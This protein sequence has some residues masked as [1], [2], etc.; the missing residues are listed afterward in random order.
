MHGSLILEK[1]NMCC[2]HCS[3]VSGSLGRVKKQWIG[4]TMGRLDLSTRALVYFRSSTRS[5]A[6]S[7][8]API[9]MSPEPTTPTPSARKRHH[10]SPSVSSTAAKKPKKSGSKAAAALVTWKQEISSRFAPLATEVGNRLPLLRVSG[11]A[12]RFEDGDD[13]LVLA[14]FCALTAGAGSFN[15]GV[16][17]FASS[18]GVVKFLEREFEVVPRGIIELWAPGSSRVYALAF[19]EIAASVSRLPT[20]FLKLGK[21]AGLQFFSPPSLSGP[22]VSVS[23]NSFP[24]DYDATTAEEALQKLAFVQSA[25]LSRIA[26]GR[27]GNV[28]TDRLQGTLRLNPISGLRSE[29][30]GMADKSGSGSFRLMRAWAG[31]QE[32]VEKGAEGRS[33]VPAVGWFPLNQDTFNVEVKPFCPV[34]SFDH[35]FVHCQSRTLILSDTFPVFAFE[36]GAKGKGKEK[37]TS[38]EGASVP[39]V[40]EEPPT[41]AGGSSGDSAGKAKAGKGSGGKQKKNKKSKKN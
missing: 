16:Y 41:G 30:E 22:T 19:N 32:H 23:I 9:S 40:G 17:S 6:I 14:Y 18:E 10:D 39:E 13:V 7:M 15:D 5:F 27:G 11:W 12:R 31:Y 8:S 3:G 37:D 2:T 26:I 21:G 20:Q 29:M 1:T 33:H 25:S 36:V 34:C 38:G 24:F 35:E 4:L 28:L